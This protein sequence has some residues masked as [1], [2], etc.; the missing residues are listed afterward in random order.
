MTPF[1]SV[2]VKPRK[3]KLNLKMEEQKDG[4]FY[5]KTAIFV[6]LGYQNLKQ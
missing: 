6:F 5:Y 1:H 3:L 2:K 4:G